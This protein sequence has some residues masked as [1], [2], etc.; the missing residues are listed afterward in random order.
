MLAFRAGCAALANNLLQAG[1]HRGTLICHSSPRVLIVQQQLGVSL[2]LAKHRLNSHTVNDKH[3]LSAVTSATAAG[4]CMHLNAL[5]E[6]GLQHR[7]SQPGTA[8]WAADQ[9]NTA[10]AACFC[11]N[12]FCTAGLL[13]CW[14]HLRKPVS[15]AVLAAAPTQAYLSQ[16]TSRVGLPASMQVCLNSSH[17]Q[18]WIACIHAGLI[19]VPSQAVLPAAG[20]SQAA[21][22]TDQSES[23]EEDYLAAAVAATEAK[24]QRSRKVKHRHLRALRSKLGSIRGKDTQSALPSPF[25]DQVTVIYRLKHCMYAQKVTL[26]SLSYTCTNAL[27]ATLHVWL[28]YRGVVVASI[29]G[30]EATHMHGCPEAS[31]PCSRC[32]LLSAAQ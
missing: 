31:M 17:K 14:L 3:G 12:T 4:N 32:Y 8:V 21:S 10:T 9:S 5:I 2:K 23:D 11:C 18:G 6:A 15:Q 22:E 20:V 24:D 30:L 29:T 16:I 28:L 26:G 25:H 13:F 7:Q 19:Y 27:V 1:C